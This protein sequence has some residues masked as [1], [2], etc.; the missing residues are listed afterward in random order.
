[1]FWNDPPSRNNRQ[2][3]D[4]SG[5]EL[6]AV[7]VKGHYLK[8]T[9]RL[10]DPK[11]PYY[12]ITFTAPDGEEANRT[13]IAITKAAG[14]ADRFLHLDINVRDLD[15]KNIS[16]RCRL[17][18]KT[19]GVIS[20]H[21]G[22]ASA[23][24]VAAKTVEKSPP[25]LEIGAFVGGA[26][27][28]VKKSSSEGPRRMFFDRDGHRYDP[29]RVL[30]KPDVT[31]AEGV[32]TDVPG[33]FCKFTGTSAAAPQVAGIAALMWSKDRSLTAEDIKEAL[34]ES[35]IQIEGPEE[36][37]PL[38]GYG[39]VNAVRALRAIETVKGRQA[40]NRVCPDD[41]RR[42]SEGE[43]PLQSSMAMR[44]STPLK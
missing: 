23:F 27:Q 19:G 20:G 42:S 41:Y 40:S 32:T 15:E 44:R 8:G 29:P 3:A 4:F 25:D 33:E 37:N 38:S 1:V 6:S 9:D 13:W 34:R 21:H 5:Y 16:N 22:A 17:L 31:A 28:H 2:S 30:R 35:A 39:I 18:H 36:W 7:D 14:K 24:A 11:K 26:A 43:R 12:S 10:K